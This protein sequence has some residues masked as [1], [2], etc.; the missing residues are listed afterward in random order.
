LAVL[1]AAFLFV[2]VYL[3]VSTAV[4]HAAVDVD[5]PVA[6]P[7]RHAK[8]LSRAQLR[9]NRFSRYDSVPLVV[10]SFF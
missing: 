6:A 7:P 10:I 2:G 3:T 4:K 5:S 9:Q 1:A 8:H